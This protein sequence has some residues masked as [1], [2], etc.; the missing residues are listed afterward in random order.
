MV[1]FSQVVIDGVYHILLFSSDDTTHF[2]NYLID[3]VVLLLNLL[4]QSRTL[5]HHLLLSL[6][7]AEHLLTGYQ[8]TALSHCWQMPF[9]FNGKVVFEFGST[10]T[11][12]SGLALVVGITVRN[13]IHELGH[14]APVPLHL[15]AGRI[16]KVLNSF[17]RARICKIF[18][19]LL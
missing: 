12:G 13:P 14:D 1:C 3:L 4:Q 6:Y 15:F 7:V 11:I 10:S 19:K 9:L 2:V 16:A 5:S 17:L 8:R 18:G